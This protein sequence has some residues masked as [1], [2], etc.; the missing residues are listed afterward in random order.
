MWG[1]RIYHFLRCIGKNIDGFIDN[2]KSEVIDG[3]NVYHGNEIQDWELGTYYIVISSGREEGIRCI[4]KQLMQIGLK[5]T[6]DFYIFNACS[7]TKNKL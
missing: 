4:K 1:K 2:R 5:E 3:Y 7:I 6:R